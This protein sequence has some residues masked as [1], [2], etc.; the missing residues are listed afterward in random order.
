MEEVFNLEKCITALRDK[1][2]IFHS[3]ADFQF[4]LAWEIQLAYPKAVVHLE[5]CP[6]AMPNMHIDIVVLYGGK[7]YPIELKY[8]TANLDVDLGSEAFHL[9]NHGAQD[10]GKY[11]CMLDIQRIESMRGVIP[12]FE[13]GYA[14]WLTNDSLYW[15]APCKT[16]VFYR[17]FSI[18]EGSIKRGV[19]SWDEKTGKGTTKGRTKPVVLRGTYTINWKPYSTVK[20]DRNGE[21]YYA[22][23]EVKR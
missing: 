4:A 9:K 21:F 20:A 11:D 3:E 2:E 15:K 18:H 7:F 1:R 17:E 13:K 6:K 5:Y 19:M 10:I 8:K 22:L 14:V 16:G 23:I 12:G